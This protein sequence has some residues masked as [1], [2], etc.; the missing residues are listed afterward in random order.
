MREHVRAS[1]R[2]CSPGSSTPQ[3]S[4][5]FRPPSSER[6]S[7]MALTHAVDKH[8]AQL[9]PAR[10]LFLGGI[11]RGHGH[12]LRRRRPRHRAGRRG[13]QRR[14][15]R[16]RRRPGRRRGV[17]RRAGLARGTRR[18]QRSEV[19]R[20]AFELMHAD[21]GPADRA[22][23]GRERQARGGRARRGRLRRRVLPLVRRGGGPHRAAAYGESPAGGTRTVV[24]H[25][26][27][28]VAALVT[29]WNFPAAMATRKIAPALA[30][31]CTVV[32][33]PAAETPLTALAITRSPR[34]GG[35][36]GRGGQ[37]RPRHRCP[38]RGLH[39]APGPAGPQ[40]LVHRLD[41]GRSCSCCGRP[42]TESSTPPWSWAATP[43]SSSP[44]TRTWTPRSKGR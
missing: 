6:P 37:P 10:G 38:S 44:T 39:M 22:D 11:W 14:H 29:P 20:A 24:T 34:R 5:H 28:G 13:R 7:P 36:P 23:H 40:D 21:V 12:D 35:C 31:G 2:A 17:R 9:E 26:P 42:R 3:L 4:P 15:R 32:V 27:V 18:A 16:R 19:L 25:R 30:A 43:R 41:T 8:I 1:R 33:K